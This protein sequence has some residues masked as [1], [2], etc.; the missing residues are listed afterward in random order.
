MQ[1]YIYIRRTEVNEWLNG[2]KYGTDLST[3]HEMH[4]AVKR[5]TL[6]IYAH[7]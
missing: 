1:I 3:W 6:C 2:S 4:R 5:G 7:D